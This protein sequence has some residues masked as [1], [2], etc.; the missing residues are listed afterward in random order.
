MEETTEAMTTKKRKLE[1]MTN[2]EQVKKNSEK[3]RVRYVKL[4]KLQISSP[5]NNIK[6][7]VKYNNIQNL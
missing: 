2:A 3:K 4:Y 7:D 5:I 6:D 1:Q